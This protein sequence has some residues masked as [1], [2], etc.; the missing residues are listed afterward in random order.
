MRLRRL[1]LRAVEVDVVVARC[2]IERRGSIE[3]V[4]PD[5]KLFF[6]SSNQHHLIG[7]GIPETRSLG[8]GPFL[9]SD[10]AI[11]ASSSSSITERLPCLLGLQIV[12]M[13]AMNVWRWP[14]RSVLNQDSVGSLH[15]SITR[16]FFCLPYF[17]RPG[18]SPNFDVWFFVRD[19]RETVVVR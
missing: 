3:D 7:S 19:D 10:N 15:R 17:F 13:I 4:R 5:G 16:D 1:L 14:P 9:L 11:S 12:N 2:Y 18:P 8:D 6:D